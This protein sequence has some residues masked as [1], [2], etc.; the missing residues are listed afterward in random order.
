MLSTTLDRGEHGALEPP[1]RARRLQVGVED[2]TL[3]PVE[4]DP[5]TLRA[6]VPRVTVDFTPSQQSGASEM[7]TRVMSD[8]SASIT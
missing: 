6:A 1:V 5:A 2:G 8:P 3:V 4:A 7:G